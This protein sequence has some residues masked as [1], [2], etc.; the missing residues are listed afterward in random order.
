M[1]RGREAGSGC[2]KNTKCVWYSFSREQNFLRVLLEDFGF[3]IGDSGSERDL[4]MQAL[5]KECPHG[6]REGFQ[7]T[8]PV[9]HTEREIETGS[10][11]GSGSGEGE[12]GRVRVLGGEGE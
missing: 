5:Q 3:W 6:A 11:S 8:S 1:E 9:R 7:K 10:E 12:L 2:D 4:W